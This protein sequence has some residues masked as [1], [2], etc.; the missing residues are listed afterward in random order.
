MS[1]L[2]PEAREKD[3]SYPRPLT[4]VPKDPSKPWYSAFAIGG[5]TLASC[6]K[7]MCADAGI[8]GIKTNHCLCATGASEL[9][10][11]GFPEKLSKKELVIAPL[12]FYVYTSTQP[13]NNPSRLKDSDK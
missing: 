10:E 13:S 4:E 12:K 3:L 6:F 5:N 9:F 7:N 2:P 11:A 8:K 1:K